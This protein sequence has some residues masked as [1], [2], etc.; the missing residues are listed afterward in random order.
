MKRTTRLTRKSIDIV[1]NEGVIGF[2]KKAVKYAYRKKFPEKIKRTSGDILFVN[3]CALPHPARYRVTHQIEQLRSANV[4]TDEVFYDQLDMSYLNYYRGFVFYR[5]PITPTVSAFIKEAK[6]RN[7]TCFFDVDDLVIDTKYTDK[8]KFIANMSTADKQ[9]YDDGVNRMKE[10]LQLCDYG[11]TSTEALSEELSHY[12]KEVYVN[13][14]V[15]SDEMVAHSLRAVEAYERPGDDTFT[16]GYF[17]GSITHND[18]FKL[19]LPAIV[20]LFEKYPEVKLKI[21]G[22]LDLPAE[23]SKYEDRI[24]ATGFIDWRELPAEIVKCDVNIAP[25]ENTLFN[26]AKSENKWL[27]AALVGVPTIATDVGAFRDSIERNKDGILVDNSKWY[28]SLEEMLL[29]REE[30]LSIGRAAQKKAIK[31]HTTVGACKGV[32]DFILSKLAPNIAFVLPTS[33]ISGGVNVVVKHA[34]ILMRQG[35]DVTLIDSIDR[36]ALQTAQKSYNYRLELSGYNMFIYHQTKLAT[37]Y[38]VMVATLWTTLKMVKNYPNVKRRM[39]LV[40]GFETDFHQ[41]GAGNA[42]FEANSTYF[43]R[44][45]VEYVTISPWCQKWL[46]ESYGQEAKY[47][48]NGI[49]LSTYPF[50]E[51]KMDGRINILIEGDS[52]TK[53]KNTDE[54]FRIIEKL[55][56]KKY[57]ISYLSYHKDPKSWYIVDEFYNR[58][59]PEEVGKVYA[60]CDI[61]IKT[62]LLESF[63]YPPLE[64]MAT[65]GFV[66]VIPNDGNIEYLKDEE[67][68]LMFESGDEEKALSD[69]QR[70]VTDKKLRKKLAENGRKKAQEYS[71]QEVEQQIVGMYEQ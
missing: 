35:W 15:A 1:K 40:Q 32:T 42:K 14:N 36:S 62:S 10:T 16:I 53:T 18:D 58:I 33:D 48:P 4:A 22:I 23:L 39:Y 31:F 8:I 59:P 19:V 44:T 12:V 27:E 69:I 11:I 51:R 28:Q 60:S 54:A 25:M 30:A 56:R 34:S 9:L 24:T 7:K 70:I 13:R 67:N 5:C 55:D 65:G 21:G 68:C 2:S 20:K 37:S 6:K 17:S 66:V 3:G 26:R 64:M 49:D 71:W 57:H 50:H 63:S 46:A 52:H 61:L 29:N 47:A 43:D 41:W 38:D 45:G